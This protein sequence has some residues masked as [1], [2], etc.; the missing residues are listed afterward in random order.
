MPKEV[1]K[2]ESEPSENTNSYGTVQ[3]EK[4]EMNSIDDA[5]SKKSDACSK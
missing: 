3:K 5:K 1:I 2:S 4:K